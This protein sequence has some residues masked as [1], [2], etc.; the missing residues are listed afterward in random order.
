MW[1]GSYS[2]PEKKKNQISGLVFWNGA[3]DFTFWTSK[4]KENKKKKDLDE[5]S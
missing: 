5:H 2:L 1:N 4:I 3:N